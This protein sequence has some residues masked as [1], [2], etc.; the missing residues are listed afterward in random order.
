MIFYSHSNENRLYGD[1]FQVTERFIVLHDGS[2]RDRRV[3]RRYTCIS[4]DPGQKDLCALEQVIELRK[5]L[6]QDRQSLS[7]S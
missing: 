7:K 3:E 5:L 4:E 1:R 6:E 2:S